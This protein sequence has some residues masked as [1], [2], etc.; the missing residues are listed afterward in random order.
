M[1][2][3][4]KTILYPIS[5][6]YGSIV[7]L[8]NKFYDYKI[9]KSEEFHLPVISVGNITV[10]GTGKTPHTEYLIRLLQNNYKIALLSRGYKRKSKGF[11]L[12]SENSTVLDIGDEPYQ[13]KQ[14][15]PEIIVAVDRKRVNGI[16]Q[17]LQQNQEI[18]III[19]DDAYQHRS[20]TPGIN[21]LLL[22]YTRPIF[23][24][25]ILPYGRLR[26][27]VSEKKRAD[28]MIVTK[29]P[30][31][32]T[33]MDKRLL[34][35][36]TG[37]QPH[38]KVYFSTVG[39]G[40]PKPVFDETNVT[41]SINFDSKKLSVILVTGIANPEPLIKNLKDKYDS[42]FTFQ[43]SDHH[44]FTKEDVNKI[45]SKFQ[46]LPDLEK[47]IITTE[48]DATRLLSFNKEEYQPSSWYYIPIHVEF[49][50][51]EAESFNQQIMH[52]V[53]NNSKNS[54]LYKKSN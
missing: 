53:K 8:R 35:M 31:N 14:K 34:G 39:Y 28:I 21:I 12:A 18:D 13:I 46:E 40:T 19:L 1:N 26:E 52:Y 47:V 33:A 37:A 11:V 16:N 43:Y 15:F 9:F 22:D 29:V 20:V 44:F 23:I 24:D 41:T 25:A 48:K 54:I 6:I 3:T 38:Q 17:L 32:I 50:K 5:L 45:I 4:I 49:L 42:V 27:Q 7:F 10:G 36:N 51:N 30:K 2:T